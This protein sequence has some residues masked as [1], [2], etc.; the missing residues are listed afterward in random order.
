MKKFN[1]AW[2]LVAAALPCLAFAQQGGTSNE[3]GLR[4]I[5]DESAPGLQRV[6]EPGQNTSSHVDRESWSQRLTVTDLDQRE[7]ALDELVAQARNDDHLRLMVEEWAV[8]PS[9]TERAWTA[10]M[11]LRELKQK[12]T[13]RANSPIDAYRHGLGQM[14]DL[15]KEIEDAFLRLD[16]PHF[17]GWVDG[18]SHDLDNMFRQL[19]TDQSSC[20][21]ESKSLSLQ[22][23]PDGVRC[24]LSECIDGQEVKKEFQADSYEELLEAHPEL[25][26][27]LDGQL[28]Q[29]PGMSLVPLTLPELQNGLTATAPDRVDRLGIQT[30]APPKLRLDRAGLDEG[31]GLLVIR[32]LPLSLASVLDIRRGDIVVE[33]DGVPVFSGQDVRR[34][35]AE[36]DSKAELRVVVINSRDQRK[37]LVWKPD[38]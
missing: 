23:A 35:L 37:E 7:L 31:Q 21:E 17:G 5:S 8:D 38:F 25:Q 12:H 2:F 9:N 24:Q 33:L 13:P 6:F 22:V 10:R 26:K 34:A 19:Q 30:T 18:F 27:H 28:P 4:L 1:Q 3:E 20:A 11:A 16:D 15:Q 14:F 29:L 32:V 36:R